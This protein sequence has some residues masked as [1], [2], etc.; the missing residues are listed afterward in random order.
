[1]KL[2]FGSGDN[3]LS[4]W[5]NRDIETDIRKALPFPIASAD[6]I[7]AE[8]VIEHVEFREGLGFLQE[9]FRI[10]KPNGVL[11]LSFPDITRQILIEDYRAEF[12]KFYNRQMNCEQ[13]VWLS[14]LVD[15]EHK[16]CWTKDMAVRVLEAVGFGF[17]N[18]RQWG[19]S[20]HHELCGVDGVMR[21][22]ETI[23]EAIR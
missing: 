6:F 1:M 20:P 8:H 19:S 10:L 22:E 7:L 21:P 15:W 5:D 18:V 11:R 23:L 12:L 9:C 14:V 13:D 3:L 4:D 17:V 16:S 2:Q